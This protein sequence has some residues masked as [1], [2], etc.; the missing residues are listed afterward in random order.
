MTELGRHTEPGE[1]LFETPESKFVDKFRQLLDELNEI[2]NG[3][4]QDARDVLPM[5]IIAIDE[6]PKLPRRAHPK[7]NEIV[8]HVTNSGL[9]VPYDI[10]ARCLALAGFTIDDTPEKVLLA[11]F[12]PGCH[13]VFWVENVDNFSSP[14]LQRVVRSPLGDDVL[15]VLHRG[16]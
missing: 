15:H 1:A 9:S 4:D 11:G 13:I 10:Q 3:S 5:N 14:R 2:R 6:V 16:G 8:E 7:I 12:P